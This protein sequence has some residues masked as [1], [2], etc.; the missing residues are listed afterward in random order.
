[1]TNFF[2]KTSAEI[3]RCPIAGAAGGVRKRFDERVVLTGE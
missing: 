2:R 3:N 1:L